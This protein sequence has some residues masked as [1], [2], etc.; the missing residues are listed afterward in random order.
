LEDSLSDI[1][2]VRIGTSF[3]WLSAVDSTNSYASNV[4]KTGAGEGTVVIAQMQSAGYGRLKRQWISPKG[5]LWLSVIL[6]PAVPPKDATI[7]TLMGACAVVK[8]L[9]TSTG[10]DAGI[11]WPNDVLISGKKVCG[12]LTEMRTSGSAIDFV[13]LGVGI[14]ANFDIKEIPEEFRDM[15]TTLST[16][17]GGDVPIADL[18][19]NLIMDIDLFYDRLV[20]GDFRFIID[21]WKAHSHTLGQ[22]V[23]IVTQKENIEGIA[24]DLDDSGALIV[25]NGNG[26]LRGIIAGD[27]IHLARTDISREGW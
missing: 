19:R 22:H 21:M 23:R 2:T 12:I 16:E 1:D 8:A 15:S 3:S 18:L 17:C 26:D 27:C 4:A 9:R 10:M 7:I 5:G 6:R 11:K 13:I 20:L 25:D 14:N 24:V